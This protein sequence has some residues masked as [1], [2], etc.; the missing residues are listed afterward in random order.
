MRLAA[1]NDAEEL[2]SLHCFVR[3]EL[4]EVFVL[5]DS[6]T[7]DEKQHKRRKKYKPKN[8]FSNVQRV[9]IRCVHCGPVP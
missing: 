7:K 8:R 9:G 4:L 2:N 3:A 1:P 5:E 6:K